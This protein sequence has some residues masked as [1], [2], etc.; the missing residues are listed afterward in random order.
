MNRRVISLDIAHRRGKLLTNGGVNDTFFGRAVHLANMSGIKRNKL[1]RFFTP[2][3]ND[4]KFH[5]CSKSDKPKLTT[6]M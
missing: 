1:A 4:S 2:L 6:L 3:V 5:D